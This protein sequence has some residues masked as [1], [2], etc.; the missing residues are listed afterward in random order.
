MP[1][2]IGVRHSDGFYSYDA[3]YIDDG[4]AL[5]VP[6]ELYHQEQS[7]VQLLA[8]RAFR[9]LDC[10]GMARVDMFLTPERDIYLNE[11][12]TIPGFTAI[13]MYPRLWAASGLAAPAL[14]ARLV[15]LGLERH[16]ARAK[17]RVTRD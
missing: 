9:V 15:E 11:I 1:G 10:S 17:L 7:A 4:A 14:V 5:I 16:A 13:S 8:L 2:E 3:K 12:N 6:A